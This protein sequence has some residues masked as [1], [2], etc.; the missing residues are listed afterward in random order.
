MIFGA[1]DNNTLAVIFSLRLMQIILRIKNFGHNV[2]KILLFSKCCH[3]DWLPAFPYCKSSDFL[4]LH[5]SV[6]AGREC[7][8]KSKKK[9]WKNEYR[10]SNKE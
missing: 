3:L 2:K 7:P 4:K 10:I 8:V 5:T 1:P 9:L 6:A